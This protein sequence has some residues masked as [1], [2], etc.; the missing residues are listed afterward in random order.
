MKPREVRD[1]IEIELIKL[2]VGCFDWDVTGSGH[3]RLKFELEDGSKGMVV[4]SS[5]PSDH[6]ALKN[7]I[8]DVRKAVHNAK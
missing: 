4:V 8:S 2:S 3:Q 5:T 6:R 7:M 1:A